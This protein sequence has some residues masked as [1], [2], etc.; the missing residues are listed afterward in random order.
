MCGRKHECQGRN[1]ELYFD[2]IFLV[3]AAIDPDTLKLQREIAPYDASRVEKEKQEAELFRINFRDMKVASGLI[4]VLASGVG[5]AFLKLFTEFPTKLL[6][7]NDY[8]IC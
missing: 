7:I 5:F 4:Q 2:D 6:T 8:R 1:G 3:G